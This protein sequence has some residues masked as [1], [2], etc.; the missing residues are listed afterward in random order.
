MVAAGG[1]DRASAAADLAAYQTNQSGRRYDTKDA[2]DE[3]TVVID[4][5]EQP[6]NLRTR[7]GSLDL[8]PLSWL[9]GH[10]SPEVSCDSRQ[11]NIT[12]FPCCLYAKAL[13]SSHCTTLA[14]DAHPRRQI[15]PVRSA[16]TGKVDPRQLE[17]LQGSMQVAG[18]ENAQLPRLDSGL[19]V[20]KRLRMPERVLQPG[21][22]IVEMG[23]LLS[24]LRL[25]GQFI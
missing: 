15:L 12:R 2:G 17:G 13:G 7:N 9:N 5:F 21:V 22:G 3:R 8:P 1:G 23:E 25:A 4:A 11:T 24:L 6:S 16:L 10:L 19:L 14:I 20:R 18:K